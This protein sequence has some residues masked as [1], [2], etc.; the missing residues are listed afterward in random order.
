MPQAE[1]DPRKLAEALFF[2][3]QLNG[4]KITVEYTLMR[5]LNDSDDD[6]S[7]AGD[8]AGHDWAGDTNVTNAEALTEAAQ[9]DDEVP[10]LEEDDEI[11]AFAETDV[12]IIDPEMLKSADVAE[13]PVAAKSNG[14]G[15]A[16]D[17][18]EDEEDADAFAETTVSRIGPLDEDAVEDEATVVADWNVE[19]EVIELFSKPE[20]GNGQTESAVPA[21]EDAD[22]GK[23]AAKRK[24]PDEPPATTDA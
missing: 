3:R 22:K 14:D 10:D 24:N 19:N 16:A 5:G 11:D 6:A 12:H 2:Y 18:F 13:T 23:P 9:N 4:G 8:D 20:S 1:A 15:D 17:A 7:N 21:G